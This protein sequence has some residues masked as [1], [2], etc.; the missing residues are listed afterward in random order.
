MIQ[1]MRWFGPNDP[2]SLMDLRQAGC[3]GVVTALHH[4]PVG[5]I[6]SYEEI[7]KR[8][9]FIEKDNRKYS[10]LSWQVVESL[11]VHEDIKKGLESRNEYIENYKISLENLAKAEIYTICYN[12]MPVLDWSR[13]KLNLKMTDGGEA[14]RFVWLD[15]AIFDLMI[16]KRPK[17]ENS[18]SEKVKKDAKEK[19][20]RMNP[21][22]LGDLSKTILLGLPGSKVG[23]DISTFQLKLD[24]YKNID[25][26]KL[27]ENLYYFISQI[28]PTAEKNGIKLCIHPDDPPIPLLGLPRVVKTKKD[29][30][31]F[32]EACPSKANGLTFC[33]GSLGVRQDNN[34]VE[35]VEMFSNRIYF[36]HLRST[37]IEK[38]FIEKEEL[39]FH[40]AQHLNG[41]VD[42][43]EIVK[44]LVKEEKTRENNGLTSWKIPM[45]PDHGHL[46]LDDL[47]KKGD[48]ESYPG[49]SAIGRL[50]GLAEL[51]GLEL[52][53]L[54]EF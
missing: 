34:L 32:F 19:F 47:T 41:D 30:L 20:E 33:T 51:R 3:S 16:L 17:A 21:T 26:N 13:T 15:F 14:L 22:E 10:H 18:Y 36:A 38:E 5:E 31:S 28:I 9:S 12:F 25:E 6:W 35:L 7:L 8:R 27:K 53:I 49:Y 42:M 11:P 45:R 44:I 2:V 52:A 1:T 24:E 46:I 48:K 50:K 39:V 40:E 43:F 23:F 4:I 29:L 54:K 37:K